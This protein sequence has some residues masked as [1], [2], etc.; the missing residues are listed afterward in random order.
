MSACMISEKRNTEYTARYTAKLWTGFAANCVFSTKSLDHVN[1]RCKVVKTPCSIWGQS[2][3]NSW[4]VKFTKKTNK[5]RHACDREANFVTMPRLKRRLPS[6]VFRPKKGLRSH[7]A[8][9]VLLPLP[10]F[11]WVCSINVTIDGHS[12][13]VRR[14]AVMFYKWGFPR[15][16][17]IKLIIFFSCFTARRM[18][19][20]CSRP[21]SKRFPTALHA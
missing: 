19:F 6:D 3:T 15:E 12:F 8:N 10:E 13:H 11:S 17:L 9:A 1:Q 16:V 21:N 20:T 14:C 2:T 7:L 5:N 18:L 4:K